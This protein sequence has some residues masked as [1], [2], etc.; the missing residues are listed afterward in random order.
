MK[1]SKALTVSLP[2]AVLAAVAVHDMTQKRHAVLRNFPVV[3]HARYALEKL[4]PELR[5]YIVSADDAERPFS[6]DQRR[7]GALSGPAVEALNRGCAEAGALQNT[8][9]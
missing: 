4:G 9:P 6:R 7:Y 2:A 1:W 5:Q 3:G 8:P